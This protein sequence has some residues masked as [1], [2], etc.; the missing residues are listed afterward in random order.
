MEKDAE[1]SA[2]SAFF[3]EKVRTKFKWIRVVSHQY[4]SLQ[5]TCYVTIE[6]PNQSIDLE[7]F[8]NLIQRE[9]KVDNVII[10]T[11]ER[12]PGFVIQ[13]QGNCYS[14]FV[15]RFN[16]SKKRSISFFDFFIFLFMIIVIWVIYH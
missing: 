8:K 16:V 9:T 15:E 10:H 5:D 4:D 3:T 6:L 12:I 11:R 1:D 13:L 14:I 7:L 2:L